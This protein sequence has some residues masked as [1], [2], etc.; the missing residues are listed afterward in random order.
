MTY[1]KYISV[2][3][4]FVLN[5][6]VL[7]G[8]KHSG[9]YVDGRHIYDV[10]GEEVV[11]RGVNK[12]T[13]WTDRSG[14]AFPEIAKTGANCVR[15]V[16]VTTDKSTDL[17]KWVKQCVDNNMIPMPENHDATGK[18]NGV[19]AIVDWWTKP[20]M[21][22][23][24]KKYEKYLLINIAN[25]A[26]KYGEESK[27]R[28]VYA[29]A[30]KKMRSAG[31]HT[32][33][34]IDG[35]PYGQGAELLF[36]NY[37]YWNDTIDQ[38][39]NII[40][41]V[42]MYDGWLDKNKVKTK[43][44]QFIDMKIP[45]I[46]GEFSRYGWGNKCCVPIETIL[47]FCEEKE[48][49]WLWWSWGPDN[50][51]SGADADADMDMTSRPRPGL[52]KN[53]KGTGKII[54]IDHPYSIM[55]TSLR[56][57]LFTQDSCGSATIYKIKSDTVGGG[58]IV[59]GF[60]RFHQNDTVRIKANSLMGYK[61]S[62][63]E[64]DLSGSNNPTIIVMDTNKFIKANFVSVPTYK[65]TIEHFGEG[66]ITPGGGIY[67]VGDTVILHAEA[68]SGYEF[69]YW[70]GDISGTNNPDTIIMNGDKTVTGV[71]IKLNSLIAYWP[72]DEMEG[73][74]IA[75]SSGNGYNATLNNNDELTHVKGKT[76]NAI[77]F[78]GRRE[79]IFN[80]ADAFQ[81]GSITIA[82][83]VKVNTE[84]ESWSWIASHGDNYGLVV[85]WFGKG[86]VLF[87][88]FNGISF[89]LG[90]AKDLD[91]R[92]GK[93]HHIAGTFNQTAHTI[94][95]FRDGKLIKE[96]VVGG[97]I[98]YSRGNNFHIGSM[99]S[100]KH[101]YGVIDELR[102]YN[103]ALNETEI[104]KLAASGP[105][106]SIGESISTQNTILSIY[107]NPFS[108]KTTFQFM[109]TQA[110]KIKIDILD[111]AGN[112]VKVLLDNYQHAG[113]HII[114]WDGKNNMGN[115]LHNGIFICRLQ[116]GCDVEI[117]KIILM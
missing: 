90:S 37:R 81:S 8:Q 112:N 68:S 39:H 33:L 74:F 23:V 40:V 35:S 69:K 28:E 55:N 27:V 86:S 77:Y 29:G 22:N 98:K 42:H 58:E 48:I 95:I 67:N 4:F 116:H 113:K 103:Q 45:V 92:D 51:G 19:A 91:I 13:T 7:F 54:A 11:L 1:Y 96:T 50:H 109:L 47:A 104:A 80:V 97:S 53:I 72:M 78:D 60:G 6:L 99:K 26:G 117:Q 12:M 73:T 88:F 31:I 79:A 59:P 100:Q 82:A 62:H 76:N 110:E 102:I 85:N 16:L 64:G 87:Y 24:I 101:F 17:E 108:K 89:T 15:I 32:P 84:T 5:A 38:D 56:P 114:T 70:E 83:F 115:T 30:I 43:L 36:E 9:F 107:P 61:F 14:G 71:F 66:V 10:C 65:L 111:M 3:L 106:T 34:V 46:V 49:G 52:F 21:V 93:W 63:W 94:G 44:Q 41:S 57:L 75:D 20:E 25:E 105:V 2:V 18:I